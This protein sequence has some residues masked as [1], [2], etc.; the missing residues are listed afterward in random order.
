MKGKEGPDYKQVM[1]HPQQLQEAH[2]P[3]AQVSR[4][5]KSENTF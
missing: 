1:V 4:K 3:Q 2:L 5:E